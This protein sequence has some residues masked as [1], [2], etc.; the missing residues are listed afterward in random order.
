MTTPQAFTKLSPTQVAFLAGLIV[1]EGSFTG[2]GKTCTCAVK[3]SA[4]HEHL[5]RLVQS[6]SPLSR[7]YGPYACAG[8]RQD[9]YVI[10]WRGPALMQLIKDLEAFHLE[11]YCP[12]VYRRMMTVKAL[13][14]EGP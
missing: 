6:W 9:Q 11:E 3:M 14:D 4:R 5:L 12:H 1:G 8:N 7:L 13:L 2:D 10:H